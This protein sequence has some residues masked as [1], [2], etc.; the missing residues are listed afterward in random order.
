MPV[1]LDE[2]TRKALVSHLTV[3]MKHALADETDADLLKE[4]NATIVAVYNIVANE[5]ARSDMDSLIPDGQ[6]L[7]E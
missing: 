2:S 6:G 1:L 3:A 4:R 5:E 7:P